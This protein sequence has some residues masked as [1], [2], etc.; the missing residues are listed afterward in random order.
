MAPPAGSAAIGAVAPTDNVWDRLR[1]SFALPDCEADPEVLRW[2]RKFTHDPVR[3]EQNLRTALPR[4]NYVQHVAAK[5]DIAGEFVLLPW[6]ES[7]FHTAPPH[8]RQPAGMWQIMPITAGAM[9]LRVDRHYDARL[10]LAA[11]THAVMKLLRHYQDQF[12]DW[13]VTDYAYNAGEFSVRKIIDR[14]G[15]PP[16]LPVIPDWP[17]RRVTREHLTKLLAMACVVR[18]P[19][20]FHVSLPNLSDAQRLVQISL[21]DSM[22]MAKAAEHAGMSVDALKQLN[23][24]FRGNMV[25]ANAAAYLVLPSSHAQQFLESTSTRSGQRPSADPPNG[26]ARTGHAVGELARPSTHTVRRGESLW[27]IAHR[28][29]MAAGRLRRLNHLHGNTIR[30]GQVLQLD[31]LD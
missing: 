16:A 13:R 18:E 11:A 1:D 31:R 19:G 20:R 26:M 5:Y 25:D 28:Y 15:M 24:A 23:G 7:R 14:H 27:Q 6:V 8:R 2:A 17:V 12:G 3:F 30:P 21:A 29:S 4:L 22:P 10:D 9:G